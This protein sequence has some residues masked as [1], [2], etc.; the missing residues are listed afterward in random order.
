VPVGEIPVEEGG[1]VLVRAHRR[2]KPVGIDAATG[3]P[4][5]R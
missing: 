2:V 4:C 5:F 1:S 3:F